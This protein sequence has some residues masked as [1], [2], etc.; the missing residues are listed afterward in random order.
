MIER[1]LAPTDGAGHGSRNLLLASLPHDA[2]LRVRP[3]LKRMSLPRGR[4]LCDIGEPLRR[5][6]FVEQGAV[7]LM[8]VF[9][10]GATA[11]MATVG[12]EGL[13][14]MGI[15]LGD[16][17]ALSRY[18]V[19]LAGFASAVERSRFAGALD[20]SPMLRA[21]C[22][23]YARAFTAH[24][25]Q[26]VACNAN[27]SVKRR[28]ARLLLTCADQTG[29][30]TLVLTQEFLA[31]ILG[32]Q[33]ATATLVARKLQQEGLIRYRSGAIEVL[34]RRRLE[35][36]A[37]RCYEIVRDGYKRLLMHPSGRSRQDSTVRAGRLNG[38]R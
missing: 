16:D 7:S 10:D 8:T 18:V 25:L 29:A 13:V 26:N 6:Y 30:Q 31:E 35:A 22:E 14:G 3:H 24:L 38:L 23:S 5:V 36:A 19:T 2:L 17:T 33:R 32:V 4:V 11:E 12:C 21:A 20:E 27:H 1:A 9:E 28:C 34:D 37:C 15:L